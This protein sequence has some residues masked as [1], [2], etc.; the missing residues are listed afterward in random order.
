MSSSAYAVKKNI[1]ILCKGPMQ[2]LDDTT[3]TAG[4]E[5]A[6]NFSELQMKFC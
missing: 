5:Y 2:G 6:I 3:L 4:K 1:L